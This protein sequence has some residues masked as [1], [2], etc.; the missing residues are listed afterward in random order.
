MKNNEKI[1]I[2]SIIE[3]INFKTNIDKK[4]D[5]INEFKTEIIKNGMNLDV[6]EE[7]KNNKEIMKELI[8]ESRKAM[9]FAS[10]EIKNDKAFIIELLDENKSNHYFLEFIDERLKKDKDIFIKSLNYHPLL[11]LNKEM[12]NDDEIAN[13][14]IDKHKAL[15]VFCNNPFL[16]KDY[17]DDENFVLK[18]L[19]TDSTQFCLISNRLKKDKDFLLKIQMTRK[20]FTELRI[21]LQEDKEF[22]MKI[23]D[24][25]PVI[26]LDLN[27]DLKD[28]R[29]IILKA[30]RKETM[31]W[32]SEEIPK[33]LSEEQEKAEFSKDIDYILKQKDIKEKIKQDVNVKV[34]KTF[35]L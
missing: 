25:C 9:L 6:Y 21:S 5:I 1:K 8:Q 35:K 24:N 31:L 19:K 14:I 13:L 30:F 3:N 26:Y 18:V 34:T 12:I 15:S 4:E 16:S 22:I 2:K 10:D 32:R 20:T 11:I 23:L 33:W 28:D 29:D 27:D 17:L 7:M